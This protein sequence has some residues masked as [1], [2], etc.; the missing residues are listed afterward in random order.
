MVVGEWSLS[1]LFKVANSAS[2][3]LSGAADVCREYRKRVGA[4]L[5]RYLEG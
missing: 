1:D 3:F 2:V 4:V 5:S